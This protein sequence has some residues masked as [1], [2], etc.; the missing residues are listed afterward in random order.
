MRVR[1]LQDRLEHRP[2]HVLEVDVDP[3]GAVLLE[4]RAQVR[5]VLVVERLVILEGVLEELDLRNGG[6]DVSRER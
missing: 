5:L 4:G 3:L 1:V 2:A 6:A